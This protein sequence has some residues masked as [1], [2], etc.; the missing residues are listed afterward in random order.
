LADLVWPPA[1][2]EVRKAGLASILTAWKPTD[3]HM[4][5]HGTIL[6]C[7]DGFHRPI[8]DDW[9]MIDDEGQ[10]STCQSFRRHVTEVRRRDNKN[11]LEE[12]AQ[13]QRSR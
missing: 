7:F 6:E 2:R 3:V 4:A 1:L 8:S 13:R 5:K 10:Q 9:I 11:V 12:V